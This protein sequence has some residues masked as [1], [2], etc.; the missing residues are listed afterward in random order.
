[1]LGFHDKHLPCIV[2]K[3]SFLGKQVTDG[4]ALRLAAHVYLGY[5][6]GVSFLATRWQPILLPTKW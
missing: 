6:L 4:W 5:L 2:T 3:N 1:M